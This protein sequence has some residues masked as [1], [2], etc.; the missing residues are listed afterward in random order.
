MGFH[1]IRFVSM[2]PAFVIEPLLPY[3]EKYDVASLA[4]RNTMQELSFGIPETRGFIEEMIRVD[5]P[6]CGLVVDAGIFC[7]RIP[8]VYNDY[9]MKV[10]G[11]N[12]KVVDYFN[13]LFDKGLDGTHAFDEHHNMKPELAAIASEKGYAIYY[14]G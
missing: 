11:T 6:Y 2:V 7:R 12:P 9:N 10:L 1:L 13:S 8:R 14:A 4:L 3:A 5:S